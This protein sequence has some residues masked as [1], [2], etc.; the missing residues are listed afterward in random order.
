MSVHEAYNKVKKQ[1]AAI[2]EAVSKGRDAKAEKFLR[3]LIQGQTSLS[4]GKDYAV[5]SLCN[6]AQ[7]CADMFRI[8]FE[9]ICL[10]HALRLEPLDAWALIQHGDH[11]KR[12]GNYE[13]A[14]RSFEKAGRLGEIDVAR[15]A[16]ADVYSQQSNYEKA[17]QIYK[18][19]PDWSHR[20]D[21][22]TAIADNLRK[23]GQME[24]ARKLYN[25][26]AYF[27]K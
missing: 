22:L 15:S 27:W 19:I 2:A 11:L 21:V 17:I 1:I 4:G 16:V 6:I 13:E 12:T 20:P 26:L 7:R 10:D 14:L 9:A 23:M 3:E 5:K 24:E 18:T 8:D 25:K